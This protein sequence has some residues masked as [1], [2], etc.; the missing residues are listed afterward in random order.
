MKLLVTGGS[1]FIGSNFIHHMLEKYPTYQIINLDVLTYAGCEMTND[2]VRSNPNYRFVAGDICDPKIVNELI[3]QVDAVVHFA[4]ESHVDNSIENAAIFTM[5]NVMGTMN[6]LEAALRNGK[7][8]FHHI[9]TDE[10]YGHLHADDPAFNE[11]TAYAPRSP[12]SASKASSD[13]MVMAYFHTHGLPVTISNCSNNYGPYQ[14]PEKLIPLFIT[15]LINGKQVPLYGDGQNVRDWIHVKDHNRAV[16]L[17]LHQGQLGH[18]YCVG[19]NSERTN[20]EITYKLLELLGVG[21]E[22]IKFVEDRKGHDRRYA[23]NS[24]KICTQLNWKP[25]ISFEDGMRETVEWYKQNEWWKKILDGSYRQLN[26]S[27]KTVK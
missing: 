24:E 6:L 9:S 3:S 4:A 20:K 26:D 7:K 14:F 19:A 2:V 21:E 27:F 23:I 13:H 16:D 1:G 8:R 5:T 10:V 18:T 12:Y 11:D 15:N 17:I 22:M 25:E